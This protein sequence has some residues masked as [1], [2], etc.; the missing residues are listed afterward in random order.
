MAKIAKMPEV[1]VL[2]T[3][4]MAEPFGYR[5]KA[6]IPVR[7]IDGQ[8]ATG[9]YKKNSHDLVPIEDFLYPR[10][11]HRSSNQSSQRYLATVPSTRI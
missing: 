9:F 4:G 10:S 2:P 3:V 8:L 11:C 7:R 5:N 6:Q 1:P